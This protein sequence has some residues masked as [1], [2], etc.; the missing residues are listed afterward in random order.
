LFVA[1]A[2]VLVGSSPALATTPVSW[3]HL[4][5]LEGVRLVIVGPDDHHRPLIEH[6]VSSILSEANLLDASSGP[7]LSMIVR[8]DEWECRATHVSLELSEPARLLRTD[9]IVSF[10]TW[11][12]DFSECTANGDE[13]R[14]TA[15][16]AV[17]ELLA[18]IKSAREYREKTTSQ[19]S[20]AGAPEIQRRMLSLS[21]ATVRR[22][23]ISCR[24]TSSP[25]L[26]VASRTS[27]ASEKGIVADTP[28]FIQLEL[29]FSC[30]EIKPVNG[31][32]SA[33][34]D[35]LRV[36]NRE[37]GCSAAVEGELI[38]VLPPQDPDG[39][40]V[41]VADESCDVPKGEP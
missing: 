20:V 22:F 32:E 12:Q 35:P 21:S 10:T 14:E 3:Q 28:A 9:R 37:A 8:I 39:C 29:P 19:P 5:K 41:L 24:D 13:V 16:A 4:D 2:L 27:Y 15:K 7:L 11:S 33:S 40:L 18:D 6:D 1:A 17:R 36:E 23:E 30:V 26:I 38:K 31:K 34:P 25:F